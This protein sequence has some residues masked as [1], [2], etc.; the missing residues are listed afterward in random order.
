MT[1]LA[2]ERN[3]SYRTIKRLLED[4]GVQI[5]NPSIPRN[6]IDDDEVVRLYDSGLS[7]AALALMFG[8][9]QTCIGTRL[10]KRGVSIRPKT[11]L[12]IHSL[13]ET[14]F[15]VITEQ[16]A[17]WLGFLMADGSVTSSKGKNAVSVCASVKDFSHL[18]ALR[19]WLHA[20]CPVTRYI[21]KC[22]NGALV[23][24]CVFRFSSERIVA[25]LARYG[26]VPTKSLTAKVSNDLKTDRHFWRGVLDGDGCLGIYGM[27]TPLVHLSGSLYLCQQFAGFASQSLG[28][29]YRARVTKIGRYAIFRLGSNN[30]RVMASALYSNCTIYLPR[31]HAIA[32]R[33]IS[34][35]PTIHRNFLR[36]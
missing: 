14:A 2:A 17:Y 3:L 22:S 35:P 4:N 9:T 33:I 32:Q 16:S 26:V 25:A 11:A 20:T 6:D 8:V 36:K 12:R 18:D 30:A 7:Q 27:S 15:D 5:I 31:K 34:L 24:M 13:R 23:K 1:V 10:R 19:K 21:S 28:L 29:K